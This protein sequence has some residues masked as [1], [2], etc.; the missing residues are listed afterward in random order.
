MASGVANP[1]DEGTRA[2]IL[3]YASRQEW[4]QPLKHDEVCLCSRFVSET[5]QSLSRMKVEVD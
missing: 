2:Q 1:S 5:R 3:S 4:N